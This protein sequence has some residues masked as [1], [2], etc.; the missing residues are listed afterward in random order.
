MNIQKPRGYWTEKKC[1]T[2]ALNYN[3]RND[4]KKGFIRNSHNKRD[5]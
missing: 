1:R 2:E 5:Y 4:F 3:T